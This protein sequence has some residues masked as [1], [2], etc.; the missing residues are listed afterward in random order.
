MSNVLFEVKEL[1]REIPRQ[2][3]TNNPSMPILTV[4]HE[5]QECSI[6]ERCRAL[7]HVCGRIGLQI[8]GLR[9]DKTLLLDVQE[10]TLLHHVVF[11]GG[12]LNANMLRQACHITEA[13][14]NKVELVLMI[15]RLVVIHTT[16]QCLKLGAQTLLKVDPMNK[17]TIHRDISFVRQAGEGHISGQ[18]PSG[19]RVRYAIVTELVSTLLRNHVFVKMRRAVPD[20]WLDIGM[21]AGVH[22][23]H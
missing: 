20:T 18:A 1:K 13:V 19:A 12:E 14:H 9:Y 15:V 5:C 22:F 17:G 6:H 11:V 23:L 7:F 21:M 16:P 10:L 8:D 3:Q 2:T 4:E